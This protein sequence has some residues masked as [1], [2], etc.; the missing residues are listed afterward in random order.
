MC[1][2][3][4]MVILEEP[5]PGMSSANTNAIFTLWS[6]GTVADM[7]RRTTRRAES[8]NLKLELVILTAARRD[9]TTDCSTGCDVELSKLETFTPSYIEAI[10]EC[11]GE[12]WRPPKKILWNGANGLPFRLLSVT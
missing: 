9:L 5:V 3:F 1:V 8:L 7:D 2:V 12:C 6:C 10:P 11:H 4:S